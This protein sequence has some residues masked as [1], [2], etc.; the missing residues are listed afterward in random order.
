MRGKKKK[1]R[2]KDIKVNVRVQGTEYVSHVKRE[3]EAW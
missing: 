1:K 2:K 3:R